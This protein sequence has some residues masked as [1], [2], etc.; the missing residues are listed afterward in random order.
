MK[1]REGPPRPRSSAL[2]V[3]RSLQKPLEDASSAVQA[4][5]LP[6]RRSRKRAPCT[7]ADALSQVNAR[8]EAKKKASASKKEV[9][10]HSKLKPGVVPPHEAFRGAMEG[11]DAEP[12]AFWMV[13]EVQQPLPDSHVPAT[14]LYPP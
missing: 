6:E 4:A 2:Q 12:S 1:V 3:L 13:M 7:F 8:E 11:C 10:K 14:C 5:D 9:K